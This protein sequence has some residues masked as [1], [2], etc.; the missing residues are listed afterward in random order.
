MCRTMEQKEIL[1]HVWLQVGAL[2]DTSKD[3]T[4]AV[5]RCKRGA[6]RLGVEWEEVI[7]RDR[8]REK[9]EARQIICKYL[10]DCGWTY[11]SIGRLLDR[12]HATAMYSERNMN[13]L[14]EYDKDIHEK[15]QIFLNA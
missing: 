14:L 11:I 10:R 5:N 1:T 13:H 12:D 2:H 8:H 7:G 3:K 9:V 15:W 4:V 6:K